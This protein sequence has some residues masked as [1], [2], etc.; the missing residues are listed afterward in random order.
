[1]GVFVF[2][3][4]KLQFPTLDFVRRN[5][6]ENKSTSCVMTPSTKWHEELSA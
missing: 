2:N 3:T 6:D 4:V 5:C 1:M